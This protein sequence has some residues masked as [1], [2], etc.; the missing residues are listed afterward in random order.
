MKKKI[1]IP[2]DFSKNAWNALIYA[3]TLFKDDECTFYILNAFQ[4]YHFTT[5]SLIEPEPG[6]PAY[7]QARE[8]SE[9]GLEQLIDGISIRSDNSKHKF[10]M[11]STYNS[12]LEAVRTTIKNKHIDLLVMG[13][14]GQNNPE[15]FLYG[16]NAINVMEKLRD[17]PIIVVPQTIKLKENSRKEIVFATTFKSAVEPHELQEL[18]DVATKLNAAIR[19]LYIQKNGNLTK[20][21]EYNKKELQEYLKN[22]VHTFHTLTDIKVVAG[23]HSFIESRGSDMLALINKKQNFLNSI[24]SRTLVHEIGFKPQVPLLVMHHRK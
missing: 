24:F 11:V 16:S 1:L 19:V 2:T 21:Q 17:C 6:Q 14:R 12:V 22:V 8:E 23:I 9:K 13:T 18:L 5:D 20:D 10:E 3:T 15:N 7:E 4:L